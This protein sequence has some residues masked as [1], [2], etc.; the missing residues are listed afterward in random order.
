[1]STKE[2]LTTLKEHAERVCDCRFWKS[3]EMNR[4]AAILAYGVI[5]QV[6]RDIE[7]R[8]QGK[9]AN[10]KEDKAFE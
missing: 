3:K 10:K 8:L 4:D 6:V 1:M 9:N 7:A 2:V 5:M